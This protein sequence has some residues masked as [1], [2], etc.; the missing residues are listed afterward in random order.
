METKHQVLLC[1]LK[2]GTELPLKI[3]DKIFGIKDLLEES[4]RLGFIFDGLDTFYPINDVQKIK[5]L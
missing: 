2:D 4:I 5:I 1:T 3:E